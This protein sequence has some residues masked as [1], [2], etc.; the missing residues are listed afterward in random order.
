MDLETVPE[1]SSLDLGEA[2]I[3][4]LASALGHLRD[5]L[6]TDGFRETADVVADLTHRCER[7]LEEKD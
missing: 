6:W 4:V 2:V 7:Y 3:V 5:G 1:T